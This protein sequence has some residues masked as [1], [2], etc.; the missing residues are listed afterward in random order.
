MVSERIASI[1]GFGAGLSEEW[2]FN[3]HRFLTLSKIITYIETFG[4]SCQ[5]DNLAGLDCYYIIG[6]KKEG[7]PEGLC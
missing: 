7:E 3:L 2:A 1:P 6:I 5:D 4:E